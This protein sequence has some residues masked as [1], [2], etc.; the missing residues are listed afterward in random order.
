[1]CRQTEAVVA[2]P[3]PKEVSEEQSGSLSTTSSPTAAAAA[4]ATVLDCLVKLR[5]FLWPVSPWLVVASIPFLPT[6]VYLNR[7]FTVWSH[8]LALVQT[9]TQSD[10]L[11]RFQIVSG[12]GICMGWYAALLHDF[13]KYGRVCDA[14][15]KNMPPNMKAMMLDATTGN[16]LFTT[17]SIQV[18][19]ISHILDLIAHP[20]MLYYF[21]RLHATRGDGSLKKDIFAWDVVALAFCWSR[22]YSLLHNVYHHGKLGIFY[23]GHAIYFLDTLDAW[24][25]AYGAEIAGYSVIVAW[26][27]WVTI[28]QS[29][30]M[31]QSST[32]S[33]NV[34]SEE[35]SSSHCQSTPSKT[36][37]VT[38]ATSTVTV[39]ANISKND[40][41]QLAIKG[42]A[43]LLTVPV[44]NGL[45]VPIASSS[46]SMTAS[47]AND[48]KSNE[49]STASASAQ[50]IRLTATPDSLAVASP[51]RL[52]V[53]SAVPMELVEALTKFKDQHQQLVSDRDGNFLI[54]HPTADDDVMDCVVVTD[55]P[56]RK[57]P[58]EEQPAPEDQ[59]P[60]KR[61]LKAMDLSLDDSAQTISSGSTERPTLVTSTS[62]VSQSS[63]NDSSFVN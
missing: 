51:I 31:T 11:C 48:D 61:S 38:V 17:E 40:N 21:W 29:S 62:S 12:I 43:P 49:F 41:E 23:Y 52:S 9:I 50:K 54:V 32:A 47:I 63:V 57:R 6:W 10:Y 42:S 8:W 26:K 60:S 53:A 3:P 7:G 18:M 15:Y 28:R 30:W 22:F 46:L 55:S 56:H 4:A 1:M 24:T 13:V 39:T 20:G 44:R 19:A 37:L 16:L 34:P 36:G 33:T 35:T 27:L 2:A 5:N 58:R 45:D 25:A 59:S 14:L